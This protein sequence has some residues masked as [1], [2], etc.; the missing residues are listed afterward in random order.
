MLQLVQMLCQHSCWVKILIYDRVEVLIRIQ[1]EGS[2][3]LYIGGASGRRIQEK[4][5][6][7][8][9]SVQGLV[10]VKEGEQPEKKRILE[11]GSTH[12]VS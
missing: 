11:K 10:K 12:P 3:G 9:K 7:K 6:K 8:D 2:G 1:G 5:I 4:I